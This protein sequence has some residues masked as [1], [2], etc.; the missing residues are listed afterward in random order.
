MADKKKEKLVAVRMPV[1][2]V[3]TLDKIGKQ[4]DRK[5][6]WVIRDAVKEYIKQRST[7]TRQ[8]T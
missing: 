3:Q 4:M 1:Q 5:V 8:E 7:Q 6:S 2:M